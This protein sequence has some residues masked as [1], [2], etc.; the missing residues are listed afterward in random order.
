MGRKKRPLFEDFFNNHSMN[1]WV[2][3]EHGVRVDGV[4]RKSG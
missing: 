3:T 1:E 4:R 2:W